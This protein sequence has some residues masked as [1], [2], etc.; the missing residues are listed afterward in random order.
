MLSPASHL[1]GVSLAFTT[2]SSHSGLTLEF[3]DG[4]PTCSFTSYIFLSMLVVPGSLPLVFFS[5]F[6][7]F[8]GNLT[9]LGFGYWLC[10]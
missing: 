3:R 6:H 5:H 1:I 8:L 10:H 9:I 2:R 4:T 7:N